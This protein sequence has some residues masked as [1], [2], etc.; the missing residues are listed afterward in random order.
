MCSRSEDAALKEVVRDRK[1]GRSCQAVHRRVTHRRLIHLPADPPQPPGLLLPVQ[2]ATH[3]LGG[4]NTAGLDDQRGRLPCP[5]PK[6][7]AAG[8]HA[9]GEQIRAEQPEQSPGEFNGR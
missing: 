6:N 4:P 1:Q 8:E 9:G 5:L 2:P 7:S 3:R